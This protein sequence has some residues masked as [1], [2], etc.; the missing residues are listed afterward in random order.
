MLGEMTHD[1]LIQIGAVACNIGVDEPIKGVPVA[2]LD[3]IQPS[4]LHWK[5]QAC[6]VEANKSR[7]AGKVKLRGSKGVLDAR[8]AN[9]MAWAAPYM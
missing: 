7:Y 4:L 8:D 6:M 3:G 1:G 5:A 2:G 9:A